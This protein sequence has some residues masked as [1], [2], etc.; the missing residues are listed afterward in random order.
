[1]ALYLTSTEARESSKGRKELV[2][3]CHDVYED[4]VHN[5]IEMTVR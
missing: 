3:K 2:K 5:Y 4:D 1:M